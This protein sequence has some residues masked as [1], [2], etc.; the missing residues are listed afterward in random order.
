MDRQT[1]SGTAARTPPGLTQRMNAWEARETARQIEL[2]KAAPKLPKVA[3][4]TVEQIIGVVAGEFGISPQQ[5]TESRD[6]HQPVATARLVAMAL[7]KELTWEGVE[8][9][10][11]RFGRNHSLV[12]KSVRMIKDR[13]ETDKKLADTLS[14]I[15][16]RLEGK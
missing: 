10:G 11:A 5:I 8:S 12:S 16:A 1:V 6:R 15:R 13:V 3:P 7:A 9:I 4:P 14:V 2:V